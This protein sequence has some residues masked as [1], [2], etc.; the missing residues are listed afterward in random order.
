MRGVGVDYVVDLQHLTL[1]HQQPDHVDGALRHAVGKIGNAD[2]LWNRNFAH[3]LFL[4]LGRSLAL[5]PLRAAAERCDGTLA[6]FVGAQCR[7]QREAS[8]LLFA[9]GAQCR[10]WSGNRARC[11]AGTAARGARGIVVLGLNC[12]AA[13]CAGAL[14]LIL[15]EAFLGDFAGLALGFFLVLAALVFFALARLGGDAIGLIG[16]LARAAAAAFFF[17][18]L[19]LFGFANAAVGKCVSARAALFLGERAQHDAG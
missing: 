12:H 3:E 1:L 11:A 17:G 13:G 16:D 8:A 2:R 15:A 4:R 14:G 5:E 7:H 19:A 6:H 10:A 18:D 9:G